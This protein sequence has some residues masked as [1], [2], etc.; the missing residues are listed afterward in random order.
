MAKQEVLYPS[1]DTPAV[2][3]NMDKLE[4]NIRE[5]SQLAADTDVKLRPQIKVHESAD[6]ARMQIEAGAYGIEVSPLGQAISMAENG[7]NDII[8][9]H[10]TIYNTKKLEELKKLLLI[11]ELKLAIVIDMIEQAESISRAAQET[12]QN[13]PL[14]IKVDVN[15][16]LG[17]FS[18]F[19]I[20]P[21]EAM[22]ELAKKINTLPNIEFIG[23]KV[24]KL[25][26]F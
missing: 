13:V 5:M 16:I 12:G 17:G 9:A 14:I 3:V 26:N 6:I 18:R 10:P 20:P 15:R 21:S 19:G 22:L 7:F 2:L 4:T 23:I 8:L 11:P 25:A 24:T 1:L